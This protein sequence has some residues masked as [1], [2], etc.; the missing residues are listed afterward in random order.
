MIPVLDVRAALAAVESGNVDVGL[1]YRTDAAISQQVKIAFEVPIE[2][3][4][5]IVYP[6]AVVRESKKKAAAREFIEF[7]Q[8]REAKEIF[9]RHGFRVLESV[10]PN[11]GSTSP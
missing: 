8:T 2:K 7:L 5:K 6:V 1:V 9:K 11:P 10:T 3:S 4:P